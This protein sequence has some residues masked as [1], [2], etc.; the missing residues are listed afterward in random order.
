MVFDDYQRKIEALPLVG[1]DYQAAMR[2]RSPEE[3]DDR[4]NAVGEMLLDNHW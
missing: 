1:G 2:V 3:R 4:W